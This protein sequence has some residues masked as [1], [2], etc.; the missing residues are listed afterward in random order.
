[1]KIVYEDP[2]FCVI[3]KPAG[4]FIHPP[5]ASAFPVPKSRIC[6]YV[7][8][9]LLGRPVIPV[10]RLDAPTSGLVIFAF[11]TRFVRPLSRLFSRRILEK[12][13]KAVVRGYTDD[14]GVIDLPLKRPDAEFGVPARTLYQTRARVELPVAVGTRY[15][16]SRYSLID[17]YPE[18]GRWHQIRRHLDQIAHP[19]LGDSDHGDSH[20]NRFFRDELRI[21]GLCLR[22]NELAFDH[23]WT[24]ERLTIEAP[25]D[26]KWDRIEALFEDPDQFVTGAMNRE[27]RV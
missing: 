19:I 2:W 5:E 23:P 11:S 17:V 14:S 22:A 9:S 26:P 3:D 7:L 13:Y 4:F 6:I 27:I 12:R 10:H 21:N 18:T 16:T 1:M 24:G 20:H 25:R 15:S 8:N